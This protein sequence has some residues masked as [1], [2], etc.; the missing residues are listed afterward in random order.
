MREGEHHRPTTVIL[1]LFQD[2]FHDQ[3]RG[4][5][6]SIAPAPSLLLFLALMNAIMTLLAN[7]SKLPKKFFANVLVSDVMH[8]SGRPIQAPFACSVCSFEHLFTL[9]SPFR[10]IEIL[11]IFKRILRILLSKVV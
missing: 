5:I 2:P 6:A 11:L 8:F 3:A 9:I 7:G 4:F 1:N 10:R